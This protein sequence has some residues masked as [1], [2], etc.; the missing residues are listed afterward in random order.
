MPEQRKPQFRIH[1]LEDGLP[2][3]MLADG[4]DVSPKCLDCPLPLCKYDDPGPYQKWLAD[5]AVEKT[6]GGG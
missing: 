3:H 6:E 1:T 5:R 4:C 2:R